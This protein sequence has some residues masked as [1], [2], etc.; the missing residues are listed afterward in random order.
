MLGDHPDGY[1]DAGEIISKLPLDM[2]ISHSFMKTL[3]SYKEG[4]PTKGPRMTKRLAGYVKENWTSMTSVQKACID[5]NLIRNELGE[6]LFE[7][8]VEDLL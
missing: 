3:V 6:D 1:K 7:E 5:L 2:A 4:L 8:Y